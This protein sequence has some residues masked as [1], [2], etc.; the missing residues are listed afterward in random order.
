MVD[1]L[2]VV[3]SVP[4]QIELEPTL[5]GVQRHLYIRSFSFTPQALTNGCFI[6]EAL[7]E[8]KRNREPIDITNRSLLNFEITFQ[9]PCYN[10]QSLAFRAEYVVETIFEDGNRL[11]ERRQLQS[12]LRAPID[13]AQQLQAYEIELSF[14]DGNGTIEAGEETILLYRFIESS[15]GEPVDPQRIL[16][17]QARS[18][19]PHI[20]QVIPLDLNGSIGSLAVRGV[21]A[22]RTSID[23]AFI[24]KERGV[25]L[26]VGKKQPVEVV[27]KERLPVAKLV[28]DPSI[29][30][31]QEPGVSYTIEVLTLDR[32]NRPVPA[33]VEIPILVDEQGELYG[34]VSSTVLYTDQQGRATFTYTAPNRLA[35]LAGKIYTFTI[36]SEGVSKQIRIIFPQITRVSKIVLSSES[37]TLREGESAIV[38]LY[39]LDG[40]NRYIS[41]EVEVS[42]LIDEESRTQLGYFYDESG[43]LI[44]NRFTTDEH[45]HKRLIYRAPTGLPQEE[46]E[47]DVDFTAQE[48]IATLHLKLLRTSEEHFY[49]VITYNQSDNVEV[50]SYGSLMLGVVYRDNEAKFAPAQAIRSIRIRSLNH[51]IS[52]DRERE[53]FEKRIDE[54][55]SNPV[56][57]DFYTLFHSGVDI[58]EVEVLLSKEDGQERFVQNIPITIVSGPVHTISISL[59]G[60]RYDDVLTIF[61]D[62]YTILASDKYG[63]PAK[64]GSKIFFGAIAGVKKSS[65]G[66]HLYVRQGGAIAYTPEEGTL[67]TNEAPGYDFLNVTPHLDRLVVLAD[68][69]RGDNLY[70][71]GWDIVEVLDENRLRLYKR[72]EG[73]PVGG[74]TYVVGNEKRVDICSKNTATLTF[75]HEDQTY[76]IGKGGITTAKLVYPPYM[77]AKTVFLYANSYDQVRVG[78]TR[79]KTLWGTG[80]KT[81]NQ[82]CDNA[83]GKGVRVCFLRFKIVAT[84]DPEIRV[85]NV[86]VT[87]FV[88]DDPKVTDK[89]RL[90]LVDDYTGCDG[91]V[92]LRVEAAP[93]TTCPIRWE[94]GV[95]LEYAP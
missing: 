6:Q 51:L 62:V 75:D 91:V 71:G 80:V 56:E 12:L 52:F 39:T 36:T 25:F 65:T 40:A 17:V 7:I 81:E 92:V 15:T 30:R 63:N 3:G 42:A 48:A 87:G 83:E 61:E 9:S 77:L 23:L 33:K 89:C 86:R 73:A 1:P 18:Q 60:S 13:I 76:T 29:I 68:E 38:D 66:R 84:D 54:I 43:N 20:A 79:L 72:Y 44:G 70:L 67:F 93:Q 16:Q 45:G 69:D 57:I 46:I 4:L 90:S 41:A 32:H 37:L 49:K 28:V 24:L 59:A 10:L 88:V 53:L 11:Q 5:E 64:E 31:V 85:K 27:A 8:G 50:D 74:L 82:V 22:G 94:G 58:L 21:G 19:A 47:L 95:I 78:A 34:S 14:K 35:D 2:R 26:R 55:R